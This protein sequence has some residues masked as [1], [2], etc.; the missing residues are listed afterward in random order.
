MKRRRVRRGASHEPAARGG[1]QPS[2]PTDEPHAASN[3][4]AESSNSDRAAESEDRATLPDTTT[5]SSPEENRRSAR[6][7]L[8]AAAL[9]AVSIPAL[10]YLQFGEI[11]AYA[12]SF[13]GFLVV[14]CLLVALGYSIPDK[15][16][17]QT[18]VDRPERQNACG[19]DD[20]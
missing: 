9:A 7:F 5:T 6:A 4:A 8:I 2:A 18:P 3:R 14:L 1:V 20:E 16:E 15:P 12:L 10:F 13:T 19:R 11:N 17:Q